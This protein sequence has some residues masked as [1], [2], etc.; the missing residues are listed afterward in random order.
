MARVE[1]TFGENPQMRPKQADPG[2]AA[3]VPGEG[4]RGCDPE[5]RRQIPPGGG[6]WGP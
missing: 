6:R 4:E 2:A 3:P 1:G 5:Q